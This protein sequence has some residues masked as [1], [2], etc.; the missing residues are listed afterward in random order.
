MVGVD[1]FDN[2]SH[3]IGESKKGIGFAIGVTGITVNILVSQEPE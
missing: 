2:L 1:G 3:F